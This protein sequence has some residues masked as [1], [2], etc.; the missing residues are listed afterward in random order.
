MSR[1]DRKNAP[2]GRLLYWDV[3]KDDLKSW[4]LDGWFFTNTAA[5]RPGESFNGVLF[6]AD[7]RPKSGSRPAGACLQGWPVTDKGPQFDTERNDFLAKGIVVPKT[8]TLLPKGRDG[9]LDLAAAVLVL[10]P[11]KADPKSPRF[12]LVLTSRKADGGYGEIKASAPLWTGAGRPPAATASPDGTLLALAGD[13]DHSVWVYSVDDLLHNKTDPIQ[14]IISTGA[15]VREVRFVRDK[16]KNPGL[17]LRENQA[18]NADWVLDIDGHKLQNG[19]DGWKDD[20]PALGGLEGRG[21]RGRPECQGIR[22]RQ[23]GGS[24]PLGRRPAKDVSASTNV[25][26]RF[27]SAV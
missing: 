27:A 7:A 12:R 24:R 23:T 5:F 6:T 16:A 14:K 8:L 15:L 13:P 17:L 2:P 9:T 1:P 11:A 3:K 19:R 21:F 4:K 25:S 22:Q 20:S 26:A 18:M 10:P